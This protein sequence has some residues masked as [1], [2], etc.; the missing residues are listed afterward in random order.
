MVSKKG[1]QSE[2]LFSFTFSFSHHL[3][4]SFRI[5]GPIHTCKSPDF[6]PDLFNISINLVMIFLPT[7][8]FPACAIAKTFFTGSNTTTGK[9]SAVTINSPTPIASVTK[10]SNSSIF[11]Q[12]S[13]P[14]LTILTPWIRDMVTQSSNLTPNFSKNRCLFF[15]TSTCSPQFKLIFPSATLDTPSTTP[16]ILIS[17]P[18]DNTPYLI[19]KLFYTFSV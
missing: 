15:N 9:Q 4:D 17:S 16:F 10:P 2:S 8:T 19:S 14:T 13:F 1:C 12:S 3:Y 7:P 6:E 5:P 11:P 18:P